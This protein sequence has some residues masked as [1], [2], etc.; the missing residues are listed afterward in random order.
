M[1]LSTANRDIDFTIKGA[2]VTTDSIKGTKGL[3]KNAKNFGK[4]DDGTAEDGE[5]TLTANDSKEKTLNLK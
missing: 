5:F 1:D 4:E 2:D 3:D